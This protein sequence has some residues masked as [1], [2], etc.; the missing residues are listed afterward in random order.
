MLT[1]CSGNICRSPIAQQ[2]LRAQLADATTPFAVFS[3]G[4]IASAGHRMTDEAAA[5]SRRFGGRPDGHRS[6][7]L[8]ERL[9]TRAQLVLT[10]TR[11]HRAAVASLVPRASRCVFTL[12]QFARLAASAD[13]ASLTRLTA[14]DRL[15]AIAARRGFESPL[16][17]EDDDIDDPYLRSLATYE[18]VAT[19]ISTAVSVVVRALAPPTPELHRA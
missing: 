10:A 13:P 3:A 9:V 17:P 11:A 4:T 5:M 8:S 16:T 12:N 15:L 1:V 14:P 7:P 2:L 6:T 18:R 19:E